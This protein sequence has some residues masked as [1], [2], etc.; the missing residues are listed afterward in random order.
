MLIEIYKAFQ[1]DKI[2]NELVEFFKTFEVKDK[3]EY[4][5]FNKEKSLKSYLFTHVVYSIRNGMYN[6]NK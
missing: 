1:D 5:K 3:A 6:K 2:C 4:D